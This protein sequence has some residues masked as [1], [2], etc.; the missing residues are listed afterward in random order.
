MGGIAS[1]QSAKLAMACGF[2]GLLL[3]L[4]MI[5]LRHEAHGA[6]PVFIGPVAVAISLAA[7]LLGVRER[8]YAAVA[9]AIAALVVVAV[10]VYRA[11]F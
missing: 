8:A 7:L 1:T 9:V 5:P 11:V 3:A 2:V 6:M 4:T 10:P